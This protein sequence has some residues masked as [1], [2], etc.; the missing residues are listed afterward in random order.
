MTS[1]FPNLTMLPRFDTDG[2]PGAAPATTP[3]LAD[4]MGGVLGDTGQQGGEATTVATNNAAQPGV[5]HVTVD[6][7]PEDNANATGVPQLPTEQKPDETQTAIT[8]ALTKFLSQGDQTEGFKLEA[9]PFV[10]ALKR[11]DF[12]DESD[13]AAITDLFGDNAGDVKALFNSVLQKSLGDLLGINLAITEKHSAHILSEQSRVTEHQ[14]LKTHIENALGDSKTPERIASAFATARA[15]R[16]VNKDV[17]LEVLAKNSVGM[18]SSAQD[19]PEPSMQT[20]SGAGMADVMSAF[21]VR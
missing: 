10:D 21:G 18:L 16:E 17:P 1:F 9:K 8:E 4:L 12:I 11:Y 14:T 19:K 7:T 3:S 2:V 5:T 6:T 13:T 15:I 20:Q